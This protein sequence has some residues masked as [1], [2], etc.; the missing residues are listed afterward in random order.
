[1][2]TA[3]DFLKELDKKL[4]TT[5]D[6]L[7]SNLDAAVCKHAVLRLTFLKY[8]KRVPDD[9]RKE[10]HRGTEITEKRREAKLRVLC[11]FLSARHLAP[12]FGI[13]ERSVLVLRAY[14]PPH[15]NWNAVCRLPS[16]DFCRALLRSLGRLSFAVLRKVIEQAEQYYNCLLPFKCT[17]GESLMP[18]SRAFCCTDTRVDWAK[19]FMLFLTIF[20][21][22]RNAQKFVLLNWQLRKLVWGGPYC[23]GN[24]SCFNC[25][26][27]WNRNHRP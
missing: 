24:R 12:A 15:L 3:Q 2:T 19:S 14:K 23:Y 21:H 7:R 22:F 13:S 8:R 25:H 17:A 10:K 9:V 26:K 5:A 6:K 18:L 27:N 11:V 16:R 20:S 1:M 4:G